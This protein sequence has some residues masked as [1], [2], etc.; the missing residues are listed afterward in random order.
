[1]STAESQTSPSS[2]PSPLMRMLG[3]EN[4]LKLWKQ[5]GSRPGLGSFMNK[6]SHFEQVAHLKLFLGLFKR[7][8]IIISTDLSHEGVR[9]KFK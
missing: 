9:R 3:G 7:K 8:I 2:A 5:T 4:H 1:M 6:P